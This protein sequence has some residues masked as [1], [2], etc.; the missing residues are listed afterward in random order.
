MDTH[1]LGRD[2]VRAGLTGQQQWLLDLLSDDAEHA[3]ADLAEAIGESKWT[4]I[5][6]LN[7][8][9]K[10]ELV[11]SVGAVRAT[12][13]RRRQMRGATIRGDRA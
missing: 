3:A 4:T 7:V 11:E 2:G 5:R 6:E 10:K 8:L 1:S 13:Y 12:R 9:I